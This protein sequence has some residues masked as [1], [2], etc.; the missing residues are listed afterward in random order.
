M[1]NKSDGLFKHSV[2]LM[3]ATQVANACNLIFH[4]VMGRALTEEYS[5]LSTM[6]N[7]MLIINT[8]L[9]ALRT[10]VAHF[11][12]RAAVDGDHGAVVSLLKD[13]GLKLL[14]LALPVALLGILASGQLAAFFHSPSRSP[15]IITSLTIIGIV[16]V[17]L[18]AGALQG[19]QSF[20]WM[21]YALQSLS[22]V[23]LVVGAALVWW[24]SR[25]VEAGLLGQLIGIVVALGLGFWGLRR[26]LHGAGPGR[27]STAGT[28][29]Y[30]GRSVVMLSGFAVLM[31]VDMLLVR[32][33]LPQETAEQYARASTVARSIIFLPMPIALALFPKVVSSG[34]ISGETRRMLFK[35]LAM[36]GALIGAGVLAC[37]LL[38]QIPLLILYNK[39]TPETM[40]LVRITV[41]A[42]APMGFTYLLM[43]F[44][45][46]QHRF[47]V[48]P[49][50]IVC[51]ILYLVGVALF[52]KN[53]FQVVAVLGL[54]STL[55]ALCF[56]F[57]LSWRDR[58]H[59]DR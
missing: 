18:L 24:V 58:P 36:V 9:E 33:Y 57:T 44:E 21:S 2:L 1:P 42:M 31:M 27:T 47:K 7:I 17:P 30:F 51:A 4:A 14:A 39:S 40:H 26:L 55:S 16:Y 59:A 25:T 8:P 46:A 22:I 15:I 12:S 23:R 19:L 11:V 32:H 52:H 20:A 43:N 13:W 35:A 37:T 45:M 6:L 34:E 56:F 53:I 48:A 5:L 3:A 10:S 38:P 54:V 28:G 41:W 29:A 49:A 50:L